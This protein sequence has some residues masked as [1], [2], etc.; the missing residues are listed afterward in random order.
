ML[1]IACN[2][3]RCRGAGNLVLSEP[4]LAAGLIIWR[5]GLHNLSKVQLQLEIFLS[6]VFSR[7]KK[8]CRAWQWFACGAVNM[9]PVFLLTTDG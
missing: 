1:K 7:R 3:Q 8:L 2:E 4:E 5:Y 9:P 6:P